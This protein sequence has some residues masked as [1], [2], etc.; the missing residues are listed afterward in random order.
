MDT[1]GEASRPDKN[2]QSGELGDEQI[3]YVEFDDVG[4]FF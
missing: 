3:N 4:W 1:T 2:G